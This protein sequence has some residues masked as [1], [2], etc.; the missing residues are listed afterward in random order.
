[1]ASAT[2]NRRM[3]LTGDKGFKAPVRAGTTA[4]ITL[5]GEQTV[6]GVAVKAVGTTG[7]PDRVLV[8]NQ[9]NPIDNGIWDVST[10]AWSR[11]LDA[12]G[13][14]DLV[15]GTGVTITE[16]TQAL[17][18]WFI[19]TT[20][21]IVPG[22]TSLAW[23]AGNPGLTA[24]AASSGSSLVGHIASGAG[25]VATTV[26]AELDNRRVSMFRFLTASQIADVQ[27][28]T[29]YTG[30]TAAKRS[31][32]YSSL[33]AAELY[34]RTAKKSIEFPDGHYEVGDVN[35]PWT[36]GGAGLLDY[37]NTALFCSPAVTFAT[38]SSDGAD[39]FQLNGIKNFS[40]FGFP[41]ITAS[42]TALLN[43]GSN[44]VSV[45][46]GFDN[47]YLEVAPYN[48]PSVDKTTYIDGGKAL[49][50]QPSTTANECGLL[51]AHVVAN[52]CA[53]G[54]GCDFNP[55]TMQG[56]K[57]EI[58]VNIDARNCYESVAISNSAST[59]ALTEG[60]ITS[61]TVLGTSLD[62]Q[63]DLVIG[64][65]RGIDVELNINTTKTKAARLLNPSAT[66]WLAADSI[67]TACDIDNAINCR[68]KVYGYKGACDYKVRLGGASDP[69]SALFLETT[70]YSNFDFN[71]SGIAATLD[72][73]ST[74]T[75][76]GVV[77]SYNTFTISPATASSMPAALIAGA[78]FNHIY[79]LDE[80][81]WSNFPVAPTLSGASV[82]GGQ[83]YDSQTGRY[84][85]IGNTV[86]FNIVLGITAIG[87][88]MAGN[89]I[90]K[91]LPFTAGANA[92]AISSVTFNYI[93]GIN[94]DVVSGY[95]S[96]IGVILNS[97]NQIALRQSGDNNTPVALT[98]SDIT[99]TCN[100]WCSGF[101]EV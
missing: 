7:Y 46:A 95:Y 41:K 17:Q 20:G 98:A 26:N 91:N 10:A 73:E 14:Q 38:V 89:L 8:K 24:L 19:T 71:I 78:K 18:Y 37:Y 77:A 48:M 27:T 62:A 45:T 50:I 1:M 47:L 49:T 99:T 56:K 21:S 79:G 96:M 9:T 22:S 51:R 92:G 39:V 66:Q 61:V 54:F 86:F 6:D 100:V 36:N 5:S 42:L 88:A 94:L 44:G 53:Q 13:T 33:V 58:Y 43:S 34:Q 72:I 85:K 93:K 11:S 59:G 40:I 52:G 4:N 32:M 69:L 3:G 80:G 55:Y 15:T 29:W 84:T 16:G 65:G 23:A 82:E 81:F 101:Y 28:G 63:R 83:T 97:T 74:T 30:D 60:V 87:G 35:L 31:A 68:A 64:R 57:T 75:G 76:S 90:I 67:V 70:Y 12:N 25:A 2:T